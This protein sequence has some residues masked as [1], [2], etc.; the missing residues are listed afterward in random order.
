M[1]HILA[2][3][4]CKTKGTS[5]QLLDETSISVNYKLLDYFIDQ[6]ERE[7][8]S[9]GYTVWNLFNALTYWSSHIDDTF[10]RVNK[11][12][13]KITEVKMS[14]EGSKTHTAQVKR[15]DKIRE[16]MNSDDWQ[17]LMNNTYVFTNIH[18]SIQERL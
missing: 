7:S 4:I 16:F 8:G 18:P 14:R 10:E 11:D 9:L 2:N 3:N 6:I 12:T 5:K 13:G 1:A 17:A 15:E